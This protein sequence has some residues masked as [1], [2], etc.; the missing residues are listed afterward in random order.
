[1]VSV[2]FFPSPTI[3]WFRLSSRYLPDSFGILCDE[4][5]VFFEYYC[6]GIMRFSM[7]F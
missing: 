3:H 1:M 6:Y 5:W 4:L 7:A 2:A